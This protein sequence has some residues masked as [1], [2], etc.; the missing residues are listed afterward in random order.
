MLLF[1]LDNCFP[2]DVA[3]PEWFPTIQADVISFRRSQDIILRGIIVSEPNCVTTYPRVTWIVWSYTIDENGVSIPHQETIN[4]PSTELKLPKNT[5]NYGLNKI[6][7]KVVMPSNG[8]FFEIFGWITILK[9]PLVAGIVGGREVTRSHGTAIILNGSPSRDPDQGPG[10]D[11]PLQI[12]WLCKGEYES[13]PYFSHVSDI[14]I[15]T[16]NSGPSNSG[17]CFGNG[18]G[19]LNGSDIITSLNSSYLTVGSS[20]DI[21]L[22]VTKESRQANYEQTIKIVSGIPPEVTIK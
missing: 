2:P 18:V 9:S 22:I 1:T 8:L 6:Y 4:T 5:L 15:V 10:F 11:S 21:K 7:F 12:T 14:P 13:F 17:G 20:Y 16:P 19:R 3:L